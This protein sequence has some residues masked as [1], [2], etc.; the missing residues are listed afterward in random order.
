MKYLII[1][2]SPHKG[3]TWKVTQAI[4]EQLKELDE[5]YTAEEIHLME[6]GLPFCTGCSNCFRKGDKF[7][8]HQNIMSEIINKMEEAD[9]VIVST[10]TFN[11]RETALLKNFLDHLNY[12]LHRPLFFTKKAMVVTTVGGVG[13]K[14]TVKSVTG[15]LRGMG[16][17]KCYAISIQSVSW[18]AYQVSTS[19]QKKISRETGKFHADVK[20]GKMHYPKTEVLIPYNL[21]RGMV[22]NFVK[23]SEFETEDGTYFTDA[24]RKDHVY[25][26]SIPLLPHQKLAGG[27]FYCL[28]RISSKYM[29]VTYKK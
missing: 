17:N 2:G 22:D 19:D 16:F 6:T 15:T 1:N 9:G 26:K 8:P 10:T 12:L 25:D 18:N 13:G 5:E 28:G 29:V 3:N 11:C 14:S 7:C 27:L 21:F 23:G 20:S 4:M 24:Y